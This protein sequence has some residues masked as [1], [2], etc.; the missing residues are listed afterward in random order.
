MAAPKRVKLG[1]RNAGGIVDCGSLSDAA[2]QGWPG[3]E[4]AVTLA[5]SG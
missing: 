5:Q 2:V 3:R 1:C 4:A